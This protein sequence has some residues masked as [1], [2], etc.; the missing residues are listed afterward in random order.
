MTYA[1]TNVLGPEKTIRKM[2]A[3]FAQNHK[4]IRVTSLKQCLT[5]INVNWDELF[6][7]FHNRGLTATRQQKKQW[8]APGESASKQVKADLSTNQ[9]KCGI[10][11]KGCVQN[12]LGNPNGKTESNI[13]VVYNTYEAIRKTKTENNDEPRPRVLNC[14]RKYYKSRKIHRTRADPQ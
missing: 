2:D 1:R 14:L 7:P 12:L 10:I 3:A 8:S 5:F 4:S 6:A 13:R 11:H 9:V